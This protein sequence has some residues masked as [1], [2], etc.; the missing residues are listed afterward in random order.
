MTP[1]RDFVRWSALALIGAL[2]GCASAEFRAYESARAAHESC[3]EE[4]PE[5]TERC[6]VL[7]DA[8]RQRYEEYE[9]AAQSRWG[10]DRS[11]DPDEP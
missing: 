5:E 6:A 4:H 2:M 1:K 11:P 8:A 3:L 10:R 7:E 9:R